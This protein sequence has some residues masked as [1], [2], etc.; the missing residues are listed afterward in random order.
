M[1][2]ILVFVSLITFY[3]ST[4]PVSSTIH[5]MWQSKQLGLP[6]LFS[7]PQLTF[8]IIV[9][10]FNLFNK[11]N[12]NFFSFTRI[13]IFSQ[14]MYLPLLVLTCVETTFM[15]RKSK[16]KIILLSRSNILILT[17]STTYWIY[18]IC[19]GTWWITS[20]L[21]CLTGNFTTKFIFTF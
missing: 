11:I 21:V 18:Y 8:Y 1:N 7:D 13:W 4:V 5:T 9:T 16:P 6:I 17:Q 10:F 2:V 15:Y 12:F 20:Y 19:I 14:R 3:V